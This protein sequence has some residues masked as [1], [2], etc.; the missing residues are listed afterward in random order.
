MWKT[1]HSI[2]KAKMKELAAPLAGE[3]SG[4]IFFT[5]GYYGFDDAIYGSLKLLEIVT[6]SGKTLA[7]LRDSIPYY[8]STPEIRLDTTDEEKFAIVA[9]VR[10]HF[11]ARFPVIDI[12]GARVQ[13]PDGWALVR[14]SNTQPVLVLRF[15]AKTKER[16]E[17]IQDEIYGALER[18]GVSAEPASGH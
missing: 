13:Y 12:D 14:A 4:H 15:E 5:H 8:T 1:G 17:A 11:R 2:M 6:R 18:E 7:E 3:L 16:L 9:R 10:D